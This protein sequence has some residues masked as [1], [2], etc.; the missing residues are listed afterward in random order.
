MQELDA[1]RSIIRAKSAI[2][3]RVPHSLAKTEANVIPRARGV[4][5]PWRDP[6]PGQGFVKRLFSEI[7][8]RDLDTIVV[9]LLVLRLELFAALRA[10]MEESDDVRNRCTTR[11]INCI[12]LRRRSDIEKTVEIEVIY[13]IIQGA[14]VYAPQRLVADAEHFQPVA[15]RRN[16]FVAPP[17]F[18]KPDTAS[19][20][21]HVRAKRARSLPGFS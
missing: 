17:T 14:N 9:H 13:V 6:E 19:R 11:P 1:A 2:M 15:L 3:S 4:A 16:V 18:L 5:A 8:K 20:C 21:R 12:D 7:F 10:A